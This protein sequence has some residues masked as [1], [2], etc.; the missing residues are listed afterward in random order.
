[1]ESVTSADLSSYPATTGTR[2]ISAAHRIAPGHNRAPR[3][4]NPGA[5]RPAR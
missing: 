1:M 4:I 2:V 5:I 3:V